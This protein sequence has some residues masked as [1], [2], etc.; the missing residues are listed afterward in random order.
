MTR[1]SL[2]PEGEAPQATAEG[3]P[4]AV[5]CQLCGGLRATLP[6]CNCANIDCARL[7]VAC[8][9]CK[10]SC[11][12]PLEQMPPLRRLAGGRHFLPAVLVCS[13]QH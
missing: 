4:A 6:H 11:R 2:P 13:W 5:D 1:G 9:G 3:L 10:V 8:D 12:M 7:F